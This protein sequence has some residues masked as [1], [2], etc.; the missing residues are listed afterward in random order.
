MSLQREDII[1]AANSLITDFGEKAEAEAER[2]TAG[3]MKAGYN[4]MAEIWKEV[5]TGISEL[6]ANNAQKAISVGRQHSNEPYPE[7]VNPNSSHQHQRPT[8]H[9]NP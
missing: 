9:P 3:S 6:R 4:V 7:V 2:N 8:A 1:R 5:R